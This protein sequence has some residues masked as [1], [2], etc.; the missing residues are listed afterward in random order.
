MVT[1]RYLTKSRFKLAVECP[2]KLFY[3]GKRDEYH[4]AMAEDDFLAMLAEG[5]YQIGAL[6]KL[7]YPEGIE[8]FERQ[9]DRAEAETRDYLTRENVIL[10]E[11]AIRVGNFFIRIDI[12]I[13]RGNRFELIEVKAKSF[14]SMDPGIEGKRGG[15]KKE[16]LPYIQDAA[17]QTW[18]LQQAYPKSEISTFLM[19]PD[20]AKSAPVESINQMF[21]IREG[22]DVELRIPEGVSME[23]LA[24]IMLARVWAPGLASLEYN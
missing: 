11:P 18:V 10:F 1:P 17:F 15:I 4:D 12:L 22:A 3:S 8:V 7:R 9:H 24:E 2:T 21:K 23:W 16:M 6:A 19:M 14:N 20:K 5:G 13:K